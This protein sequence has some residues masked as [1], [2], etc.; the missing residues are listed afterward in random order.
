MSGQRLTF[1]EHLNE[2]RARLKVVAYAV[3]IV[4]VIVLFIPVDPAYQLAHL[5]QYMNLQF[6][7]NTFVAWFLKQV[8]KDILPPS[9]HLIGAGGLGEG[10]EVYFIAG[11]LLTIA[12]T[13]PV[14]A[15][16]VYKF[17]DPALKQNERRLVYPFVTATSIL[18]VVG[19][20]FGYFVLAHF[21][22]IFLAP[23]Y[24]AVQISF[25]V[26]AAQFYYVV[27]LI[28]AATGASFTSP[29]FIYALV[30]LR[31][32]DADFF[33]RNRLMI[34]FVLWIIAG[35][36]LTPDGGPLLDMV[37]FL[38]LVTL[39][40]LAVFFGR[41]QAR[42]KGPA[43][44]GTKQEPPEKKCMFCASTIPEGQTFCPNCGRA[45]PP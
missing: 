24:S 30:A 28:I 34:W 29:V 20:L 44:F 3:V 31:V 42:G 19:L 17:V 43:L 26:D 13:M 23:F 10:M 1:W 41:R 14:I 2:L 6:V 4:L 38:P 27:F 33:S 18:F 9:W 5:D 25:N 7:Q 8:V 35:L 39:I 45:N 21:L 11:V 37:L 15:F 40:E 12:F 36:F 32:I 16:E 22:V